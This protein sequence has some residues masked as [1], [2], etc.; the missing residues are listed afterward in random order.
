VT[1]DTKATVT[2]EAPAPQS[3]LTVKQYVLEYQK[4]TAPWVPLPPPPPT[5]TSA[6]HAPLTPGTYTWRLSVLWQFADGR[7]V[8]SGYTPHG[9]SVP[10][11][12]VIPV[13]TA[14]NLQVTTAP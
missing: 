4:D 11:R 14:L 13:P 2:W 10:C 8:A 9:V 1:S 12:T 7:T 6:V 5:A 3:G